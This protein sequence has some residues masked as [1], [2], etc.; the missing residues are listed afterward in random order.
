[1]PLMRRAV[2]PRSARATARALCVSRH[3]FPSTTAAAPTTSGRSRKICMCS[4][5]VTRV[6]FCANKQL[7]PGPVSSNDSVRKTSYANAS[8]G[9]CFSPRSHRR[10][11]RS[12]ERNACCEDAPARPPAEAW[13]ASAKAPRAWRTSPR[14]RA[15]ASAAAAAVAA[16]KPL[17]SRGSYSSLSKWPWSNLDKSCDEL[18]SSWSDNV[19][20][21]S[22]PAYASSASSSEDAPTDDAVDHASAE[23][24]EVRARRAVA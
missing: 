15:S 22:K 8:T 18:P 1:M 10:M 23:L 11:V 9:A 21:S 13:T 5:S 12:S 6:S 19:A 24:D 4:V 16:A 17:F 7:A 3:K 14:D 2:R 20:A